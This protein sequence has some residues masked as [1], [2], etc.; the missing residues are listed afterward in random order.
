MDLQL[1]IPQDVSIIP[2]YI[3]YNMLGDKIFSIVVE[4]TSQ[5]PSISIDRAWTLVLFQ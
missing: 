2:I 4:T 5:D 1:D 3:L